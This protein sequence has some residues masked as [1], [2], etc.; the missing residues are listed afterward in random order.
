MGEVARA[1]TRPSIEPLDSVRGPATPSRGRERDGRNASGGAGRV[2]RCCDRSAST[3]AGGARAGSVPDDEAGLAGPSDVMERMERASE[4]LCCRGCG[5]VGVGF[6][7]IAGIAGG[8]NGS[9]G[10]LSAI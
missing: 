10:C 4:S 2:V 5:R 1:P 7:G 3:V 9:S 6:V 8:G